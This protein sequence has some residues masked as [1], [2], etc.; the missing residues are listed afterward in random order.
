MVQYSSVFN[1][2]P[3]NPNIL[4]C[5]CDHDIEQKMILSKDASFY[6]KAG[7]FRF[8]NVLYNAREFYQSLGGHLLE[9]LI[10]NP[11]EI[12]NRTVHTY[13]AFQQYALRI[14][15]HATGGS[16]VFFMNPCLRS[17]NL[18]PLACVRRIQKAMRRFLYRRFEW[19]AQ[20]VMMVTH[21]RL[22]MG[23]LMGQMIPEDII[24]KNIVNDNLFPTT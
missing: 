15:L 2:C 7:C 23:S 20:A 16:L 4:N 6:P 11:T 3:C 19:R 13:A 12:S 21:W 10:H 24:I 18:M 22:G 5:S 9:L 14:N 17:N 8:G 1:T